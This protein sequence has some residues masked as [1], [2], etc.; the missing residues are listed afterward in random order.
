MAD[1]REAMLGIRGVVMAATSASARVCGVGPAPRRA[2]LARHA[3]LV[4]HRQ[5]CRS[6]WKP[7]KRAE[8]DEL[9][10]AC[11]IEAPQHRPVRAV[12]RYHVPMQ[13]GLCAAPGRCGPGSAESFRL[14]RNGPLSLSCSSSARRAAA[15]LASTAMFS[16]DAAAG[17]QNGPGPMYSRGWEEAH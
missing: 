9:V 16:D 11:H 7:W 14:L 3:L 8:E 6:V 17:A 4:A 15:C 13:P 1:S 2:A 10:D 12:P 5:Q